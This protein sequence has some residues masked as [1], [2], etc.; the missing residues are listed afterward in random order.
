ML[1]LCG[2]VGCNLAFFR[3]TLRWDWH[4]GMCMCVPYLSVQL[5]VLSVWTSRAFDP[6]S[7]SNNLAIEP[8]LD[9]PFSSPRVVTLS[10]EP[11]FCY[12]RHV[13]STLLANY[14]LSSLLIW[15]SLLHKEPLRCEGGQQPSLIPQF[16]PPWKA[17]TF[18][19]CWQL[20]FIH[21]HMWILLSSSSTVHSTPEAMST[22]R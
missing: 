17:P 7:Q 16:V 15:M 4:L 19:P 20:S 14:L 3:I 1:M 18:H 12:H 9:P 22:W 5:T 2:G 11:P 8:S 13:W 21:C 6:I 10:S